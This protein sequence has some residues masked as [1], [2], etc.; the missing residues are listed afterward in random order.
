MGRRKTVNSKPWLWRH[1]A[2]TA[3][4]AD[5]L[6]ALGQSV[7]AAA[8]RWRQS[9]A[10]SYNLTNA[11]PRVLLF[12]GEKGAGSVR[13][14]TDVRGTIACENAGRNGVPPRCVGLCLSAYKQRCLS[15]SHGYSRT[16]GIL[17]AADE[18]VEIQSGSGSSQ[19][20]IY[21]SWCCMYSNLLLF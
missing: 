11:L 4:T 14:W 6:H 3:Q 12:Q 2:A 21:A 17:G 15:S 10:P 19:S 1:L 18:S 7:R 16:P 20:G 9:Q 5:T 8:A 13:R